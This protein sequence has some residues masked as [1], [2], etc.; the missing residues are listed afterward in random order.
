MTLQDL[1]ALLD[2]ALCRPV[3]ICRLCPVPAVY[4]MF[5]NP[6]LCKAH[7]L[8]KHNCNYCMSS[9]GDS[10]ICQMRKQAHC[11]GWQAYKCET[12]HIF[13]LNNPKYCLKHFLT[14]QAFV[15][16][17]LDPL[18]LCFSCFLPTISG[19][20]K[21]YEKHPIYCCRPCAEDRVRRRLQ[22]FLLVD[23]VHIL[24]DYLFH[25]FAPGTRI[26]NDSF[27]IQHVDTVTNTYMIESTGGYLYSI[28]FSL[29]IW[30]GDANLS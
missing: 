8:L 30:S 2:A 4:P 16:N 3:R 11:E 9:M 24:M 13:P 17:R 29:A 7:F 14:M 23:I 5:E 22:P 19:T 27:I 6:T 12:K 20:Y 18:K 1:S 21:V 10:C 15:R 26:Q 28:P 25:P